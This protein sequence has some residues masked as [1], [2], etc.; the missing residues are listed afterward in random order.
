MEED[1]MRK[2]IKWLTAICITILMAFQLS[3]VAIA[4]LSI[5]D[6]TSDFYVNDFSGIFSE[7]QKDQL[8]SNAA[9]L[10]NDYNGIQIVITT[11]NSLDGNSIENYAVK[12][13]NQYKI[14]KDDMGLLILLATEDQ[15]IRVEVGRAMEGYI[16]NSKAGRFIDNYAI[17]YLKEN[18]F[19]EGLISL[20]EAFI[21]EISSKVQS[22][23]EVNE[24]SPYNIANSEVNN[25]QQSDNLKNRSSSTSV[26]DILLILL[27]PFV[28]IFLIATFEYNKQK[29][30]HSLASQLEVC[31]QK[32]KQV[33]EQSQKELAKFQEKFKKLQDEKAELQNSYQTLADR[34][35]RAQRLYPTVDKEVTNMINEEI[36][37]KDMML[38]QQVDFLIQSVIKLQA[39]KDIVDKLSSIKSRYANLTPNQKRYIK[40]D[41]ISFNRL[42]N[43]SLQLQNKYNMEMEEK[44]RKDAAMA[45]AA[46]ITAIISC[47]TIGKAKDLRKLEEAKSIYDSLDA[48]SRSYFNPSI[49]KQLIQ[50]LNQ[51]KHD[52]EEI[53]A[54]ERRRQQRKAEELRRRMQDSDSS[55]YRSR[56]HHSGLGGHS[57]GGGASRHF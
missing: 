7:E 55:E 27:V 42:Y 34:Y 51:A 16:N 28:S 14:G 22:S 30:M 46:S 13:Y 17:P 40:S 21:N 26:A 37:Q 11:I 56:S 35:Q 41:I 12:M 49:I 6:P 57:G 53:E 39:S 32:T 31:E 50:L 47:I 52:Q 8:V 24:T 2:S 54:A 36:R 20:Q 18:K 4:A 3:T 5:P 48:G 25:T 15:Q 33:R 9:S 44:R 29:S 43:S 1:F 10:E 45:A 19:D 23:S 38:A